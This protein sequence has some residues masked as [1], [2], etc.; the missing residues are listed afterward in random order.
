MKAACYTHIKD[1]MIDRPMFYSQFQAMQLFKASSLTFLSFHFF[2]TMR[3][4]MPIGQGCYEDLTTSHVNTFQQKS[5][6]IPLY[7]YNI[8]YMRLVM[9]IY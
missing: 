3:I 1:L 8:L 9:N 5:C 7:Q 6:L 4:I 2:S